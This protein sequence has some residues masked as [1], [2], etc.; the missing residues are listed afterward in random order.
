MPCNLAPENRIKS[1]E[2]R[3]WN[4]FFHINASLLMVD[5]AKKNLYLAPIALH[6]H[7]KKGLVSAGFAESLPGAGN[8]FEYFGTQS[9]SI[10]SGNKNSLSAKKK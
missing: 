4:P 3:I 2:S 10:Q 8:C 1:V 9:R 7:G 6:F 5:A